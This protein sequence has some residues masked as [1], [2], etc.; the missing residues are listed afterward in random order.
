MNQNL[1]QTVDTDE[2]WD[3]WEEYLLG[4]EKE[5]LVECILSRM[6][7]DAKFMKYVQISLG[8]GKEQEDT[9]Q[10]YM[11]FYSDEVEKECENIEPDVEYLQSLTE[12]FFNNIIGMHSAISKVK[13]YW[14][15]IEKLDEAIHHGAGLRNDDDWILFEEMED[16][17]KKIIEICRTE[18]ISPEQKKEIAEFLKTEEA[19]Y[20]PAEVNYLQ[21]ILRKL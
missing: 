3:T 10:E 9:S 12:R 8:K 15:V 21:M 1:P 11:K 14:T 2:S 4:K 17:A 5:D 18:T 16:A 6:S 13:A 7:L 20:E 19:G